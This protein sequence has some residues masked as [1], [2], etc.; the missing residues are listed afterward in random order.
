MA[1]KYTRVAYLIAPDS[2][3]AGSSVSVDIAIENISE[4][5]IHVAAVGVFDSE[6]RFIDWMMDWLIPL[7]VRYFSGSFVMPSKDVVVHGYSMYEDEFGYWYF[8][9][10]AE[11]RVDLEALPP[12]GRIIDLWVNKA[13]EGTRLPMPAAVA[14]DGN[15]FEIGI[16]GR[17]T[18]G[19]DTIVGMEVV[20]TDPDG[21]QRAA[22][23]IDWTG[24]SPGEELNWEYN[25][26]SVDKAGEWTTV[27]RFISK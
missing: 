10:E 11:K 19:V 4:S 17:F 13:P 7:E 27:I 9:D 21:L 12:S 3:P 22:P 1:G 14:A 20:V 5:R 2:A 24:M 23:A 8:D 15:T 25:I 26:C 16:R 18:G 6:E